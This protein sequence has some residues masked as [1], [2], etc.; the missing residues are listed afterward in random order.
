M[1]KLRRGHDL[2]SSFTDLM[3]SVAILFLFLA[4]AMVVVIHLQNK[5]PTNLP[6]PT[7]PSET[8]ILMEKIISILKEGDKPTKCK[9]APSNCTRVFPDK[10][11]T[12]RVV[13]TSIGLDP[14]LP[15]C[16]GLNF[17]SGDHRLN[18][19][20]KNVIN[21]DILSILE[22]NAKEHFDKSPGQEGSTAAFYIE[23]HTDS[24][25]IGVKFTS[26]NPDVFQAF[27]K[28]K[29]KN[30]C[31][32]TNNILL[33]SMRASSVYNELSEA[34][35]RTNP[36]TQ[37]FFKDKVIASGKGPKTPFDDPCLKGTTGTDE[38]NRR[39]ELVILTIGPKKNTSQI[40]QQK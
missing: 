28:S 2:S 21:R 26:R 18:D 13:F 34:V 3:T 7:G 24:K 15:P 6:P 16:G 40:N 36:T 39:V 38:A 14:T 12:I 9:M 25:P 37:D 4:V 17:E 19:S 10:N 22:T 20:A 32:E 1:A 30:L 31:D 5:R 29:D 11:S 35:K 27:E 23:G 33:S 8:E